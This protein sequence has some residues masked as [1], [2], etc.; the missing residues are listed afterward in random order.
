MTS[1]LHVLR[2]SLCALS[3]A[4]AAC[5]GGESEEPPV[6]RPSLSMNKSQVAIG[7]PVR[8][9]YGFEVKDGATFDGD[10]WIFMHV[11]DN[12]SEQ[13]WTDDH[14]PPVPTSQWRPGQKVEYTRTIF[15]PNYPYIGP[16]SVRVGLYSQ[17]T[18]RRL[19]LEGEERGRHEYQVA[20]LELRPQSDNIFLIF[21]DGWYGAEV[22][23]Q[24]PSS[25]WQWTQKTATITFRNPRKDA[26]LYLE[27]DARADQFP[28]P[29][30]VTIRSAGQVVA[31]FAADSRERKLLTFPVTADQL[32]AG[33]MAELVLEVDRTF[34]ADSDPRELGIRVFHVFVEPK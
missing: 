16:A 20:N 34:K 21:R 30:Q 31:T 7:S 28:A 12:E 33:E 23:E 26:T 27:Y 5:S 4:A 25:E 10:Y 9:T 18:G 3:L 17:Q 32:G 6:A 29:Q 22:D 11:L 15:V 1:K 19:P 14:Q 13:L 24:N 2:I 8:L